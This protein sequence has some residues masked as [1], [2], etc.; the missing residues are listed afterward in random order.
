MDIGRSWVANLVGAFVDFCQLTICGR[1]IAVTLESGVNFPDTPD[2]YGC[3]AKERLVGEA[4]KGRRNAVIVATKF[5]GVRDDHGKFVGVNGRPES[6]C[7]CCD[8]SL[9]RLGIG[10]IDLSYQHR[11]RPQPGIEHGCGEPLNPAPG[12]RRL[13]FQP[14]LLPLPPGRRPGRNLVTR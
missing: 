3:G 11:R 9:Q 7:A 4:I 14:W 12:T 10:Q 2:M 5:G 6:V 1:P 13:V 8:A